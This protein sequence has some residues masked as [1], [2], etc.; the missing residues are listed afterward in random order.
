MTRKPRIG[1]PPLGK[2]TVRIN[3]KLPLADR[4]KW[5]KA[6]EKEGMTLSEW[7]RAA[8]DLALVRG[9]TR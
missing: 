2:S 4:E 7:L 6:A 8:A 3:F 5:H 1:R 9:S